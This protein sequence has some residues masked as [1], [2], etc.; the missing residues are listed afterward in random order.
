[1]VTII[2][3]CHQVLLILSTLL[4]IGLSQTHSA[5]SNSLI[6]CQTVAAAFRSTISYTATNIT[7][8]TG[9]NVTCSDTG[10]VCPD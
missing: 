6:D 5:A 2:M 10:V 8:T 1:M 4:L 9:V 7:A 3:D